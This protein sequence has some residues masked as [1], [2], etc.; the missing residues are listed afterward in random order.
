M[1]CIP[2]INF[3]NRLGLIVVLIVFLINCSALTWILKCLLLS[4]IYELLERAQLTY[5]N[6]AAIQEALEQISG[7][8]TGRQYE[9]FMLISIKQH[10]IE[11]SD[12]SHITS[13]MCWFIQLTI[14][15]CFSPETGIFLNT[16]GLE[17]LTNII[18]VWSVVAAVEPVLG[19]V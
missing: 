1:W 10:F 9:L 6:K 18:Q 11:W 2:I 16:G 12:L 13:L 3:K 14:E 8:L 4:F 5:S 19:Q 15:L 7:H 17:K